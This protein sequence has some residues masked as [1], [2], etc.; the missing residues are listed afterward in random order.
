ML[1]ERFLSL[2]GEVL[3][4]NRTLNEYFRLVKWYIGFNSESKSFLHKNCYGKAKELFN[5]NTTL[6]QTARDKTVEIL[7]RFEEN[8]REDSVLR[9]LSQGRISSHVSIGEVKNEELR[10]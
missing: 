1:L 8:R 3:A 9:L 7:K 4:L 5:L 2:I 6:N 10:L